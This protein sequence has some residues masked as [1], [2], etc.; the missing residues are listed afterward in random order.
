[1]GYDFR[2][3][4]LE[5]PPSTP[6][7]CGSQERQRPCDVRRKRVEQGAL[8][9]NPPQLLPAPEED[10]FVE[11]ARVLLFLLC[12]LCVSSHWWVHVPRSVLMGIIVDLLKRRVLIL[13]GEIRCV[14]NDRYYKDLNL[15]GSSPSLQVNAR[16][17][18]S[19]IVTSW[20]LKPISPR[21][22]LQIA[23]VL[24]SDDAHYQS[25]NIY[26]VWTC[27]KRNVCHRFPFEIATPLKLFMSE[28]NPT[29]LP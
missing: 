21:Q 19:T 12:F 25:G 6:I 20:V 11:S 7:P 27:S 16:K 17:T 26:A 8:F 13:V 18:Q 5:F 24:I 10:T 29:Q 2:D 1:M 4:S 28:H 3:S 14:G 15:P 22:H 9:I 23:S